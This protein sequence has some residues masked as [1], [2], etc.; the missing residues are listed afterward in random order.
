MSSV[1]KEIMDKLLI[2][3]DLT[4]GEAAQV[5]LSIM[6]GQ[7]LPVQIGAFLTALRIK[8]ETVEEITGCA[9]V[10]RE[11]ALRILP[12]VPFS[13]DTCGTGGDA[14]GT[15]NISTAAAFVTAA[16]GV[17]VA[18]HG[19][20][21]VTSKS[22]SAD[23]LEALGIRIDIGPEAVCRCIEEIGIG[24]LFAPAH[25][26]A[27]KYAAGPRRELGF[28]TLFNILGPLA[29]PAG[30]KGQVLGVFAPEL[31]EIMT[32]VLNNL[33]VTR[34]LVVH[35]LDGLDELTLSAPTRVTELKDGRIQTRLAEPEA[36]GLPRASLAS[37]RGGSPAENA[38]ILERILKGERGP[39]RDIV[40]LNSGAALYVGGK[41][42]DLKGGVALAA[43]A[44]DSGKA[45]EKLEAL[46]ERTQKFSLEG[47]A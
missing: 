3:Q 17:P 21:S 27:M 23:V 39:K 44:I 42:S 18:K 25:H 11:K 32:G 5:M 30:A 15:F 31:T 7:L 24:F 10:L 34:A 19:N 12:K 16:G 35:G 14:S 2:R 36:C 8:G 47:T 33:G 29:N 26:P 41:A 45:Y 13:V 40:L 37:L 9:Q 4:R 43:Q 38:Q 28:R 22:G 20:R 46:K 1:F 6:D